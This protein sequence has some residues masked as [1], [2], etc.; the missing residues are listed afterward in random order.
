MSEKKVEEALWH[1]IVINKKIDKML[2]ITSTDIQNVDTK[3]MERV[4]SVKSF[5]K[6]AHLTYF[7]DTSR[8]EHIDALGVMDAAA[9]D[10]LNNT[11]RGSLAQEIGKPVSSEDCLRLYEMIKIGNKKGFERIFMEIAD[12]DIAEV[13]R[14]VR[15][16]NIDSFLGE[17]FDRGKF[18]ETIIKSCPEFNDTLYSGK[19][20]RVLRR[21][22]G[23]PNDALK[24]TISGQGMEPE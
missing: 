1:S 19:N 22:K 7:P 17:Q 14:G 8:M 4:R 12:R 11:D 2:G 13:D 5:I 16:Q 24:E 3:D 23:F 21:I 20:A 18:I 6:L 10:F 9:T 15:K